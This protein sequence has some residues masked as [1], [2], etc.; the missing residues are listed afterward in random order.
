MKTYL[1][2]VALLLTMG[3]VCTYAQAGGN[4]P[5]S[6]GGKSSSKATS[7]TT[8]KRPS[9]SGRANELTIGSKP[10]ASSATGQNTSHQGTRATGQGSPKQSAGVHPPGSIN[11]SGN[12]RKPVHQ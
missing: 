10:T 12:P 6:S 4:T 1:L 3:S 9:P 5:G 7:V 8:T 11:N 2:T